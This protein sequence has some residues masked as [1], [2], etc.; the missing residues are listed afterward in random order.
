M[1]SYWDWAVEVHGREGVDGAL[2]DLQDAHGQCVAYLLWAAWAA[3]QGRTLDPVILAQAVAPSSQWRA[4]AAAWA[5][6][7][8]S[9]VRPCVAAQA[10]QSR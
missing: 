3:T 1:T 5:R 10:A 7:T 6:I 9:R 4:R 2:I 8:G